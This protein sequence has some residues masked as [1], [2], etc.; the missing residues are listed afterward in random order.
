[1]DP[2]LM[3]LMKALGLSAPDTANFPLLAANQAARGGSQLPAFMQ[4]ANK[5]GMTLLDAIKAMLQSGARDIQPNMPT[6]GALNA[7]SLAPLPP[8]VLQF[9]MQQGKPPQG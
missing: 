5:Q 7:L 3:I 8:E 2:M 9:I 1:M 6:G 4:G